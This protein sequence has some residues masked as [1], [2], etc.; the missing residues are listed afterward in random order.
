MAGS[1]SRTPS[2]AI[3]SATVVRSPVDGY[4]FNLTQFTVGGVVGAGEVLMDVVPSATPLTVTAMIKPEEVD[5]VHV[6]QKARVRLTGLNQRFS[7]ELLAKVTVVS[8]DRVTN[9][10]TG[11]AFYRV[12]L[13]IDPVELK[14]LKRGIQL[15]PGMPAQAIIVQGERTILSFLLSPITDTMRDAFRE[16]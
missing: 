1:G 10:R 3:S 9:E 8:A 7:E 4:V 6:G 14:K 11:M 15:T 5:Q 2:S 13:Q 16:E 12:D